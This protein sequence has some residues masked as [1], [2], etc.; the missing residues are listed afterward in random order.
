MIRAWSARSAAA[1]LFSRAATSVP[2]RCFL[3]SSLHSVGMGSW[4]AGSR[5]KYGHHAD[6]SP[7]ARSYITARMSAAS[8]R[9]SRSSSGTAS[10]TEPVRGVKHH[11]FGISTSTSPT[12][13]SADANTALLTRVEP[14][15]VTSRSSRA[16]CSTNPRSTHHFRNAASEPASP[17]CVS[18]AAAVGADFAV[19]LARLSPESAAAGALARLWDSERMRVLARNASR[20]RDFDRE[21][22]AAAREPLWSARGRGKRP[23]RVNLFMAPRN[24]L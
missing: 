13:T 17:G 3:S 7:F 22:L 12:H 6:A 23:L 21:R 11:A 10:D 8:S 2:A 15:G 20:T 16:A 24:P 19:A 1:S 5:R 9:S 14:R 18:S 4:S